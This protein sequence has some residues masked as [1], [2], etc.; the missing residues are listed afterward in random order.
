[1]RHRPIWRKLTMRRSPA[2][3]KRDREAMGTSSGARILVGAAM[4]LA[5]VGV[6]SPSIAAAA[7]RAAVA[8]APAA[9][10]TPVPFELPTAAGEADEPHDTGAGRSASTVDMAPGETGT[11]QEVSSE[12]LG[13]E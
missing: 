9:Q 4:L 8:P 10:A 6:V 13:A 5:G 1:M 2:G 11:V 12:F 7:M 3:L